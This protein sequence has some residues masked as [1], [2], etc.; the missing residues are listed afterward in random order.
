MHEFLD[1]IGNAPE[2]QKQQII[3]SLK[4]KN[5]ANSRHF[6]LPENISHLVHKTFVLKLGVF[7]FGELFEQF[8]LFFA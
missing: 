1:K 6:L 2:L 5:A 8:A 4:E 3:K 7:D